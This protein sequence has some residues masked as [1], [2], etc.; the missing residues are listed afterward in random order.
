MSELLTAIEWDKRDRGVGLWNDPMEFYQALVQKLE[1]E[2]EV[3]WRIFSSAT[4]YRRK[5]RKL[6]LFRLCFFCL[7]CL[8][9]FFSCLSSLQL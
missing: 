3:S 4:L 9:F 6:T 7:S 5:I 2:L 8:G 1:V